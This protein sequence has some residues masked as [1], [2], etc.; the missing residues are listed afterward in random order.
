MVAAG[1]LQIPRAVRVIRIVG[2][3]T[4]IDVGVSGLEVRGVGAAGR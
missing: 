2:P 3:G 1:R 4:L